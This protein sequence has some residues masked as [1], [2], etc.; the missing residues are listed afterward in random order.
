MAQGRPDLKTI[1]IRALVS[2][3]TLEPSVQVLLVSDDGSETEICEWTAEQ[4][5]HHAVA[6]LEAVEQSRTNA[7]LALWMTRQRRPD[8]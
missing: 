3:H 7:F 2:G 1:A 8:V 5:Q 4:A 6:V